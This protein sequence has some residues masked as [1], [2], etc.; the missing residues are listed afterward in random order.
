MD[1]ETL[2]VIGDCPRC[3]CSV[4]EQQHNFA[5]ENPDCPFVLWKRDSWIVQKKREI[6]ASIAANLLKYGQSQLV[7]LYS[8]QRKRYY[9]AYIHLEQ[10]DEAHGYVDFRLTFPKD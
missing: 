4:R 6:T 3:G 2:K 7:R 8:P 1:G 10:S 5:C 9:H